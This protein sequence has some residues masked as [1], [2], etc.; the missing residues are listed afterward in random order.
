MDPTNSLGSITHGSLN[1][2][3]GNLIIE[4]LAR[5][6]VNLIVSSPGSRST[7]L[8]L[9]ASRNDRI[10]LVSFLDE[11][12]G[13]FYA[14]GHA[15]ASGKPAV[16]I[17]T[18]GTAAANYFPAVIEAK[19]SAVPLIVISCDRPFELRD[20]SAGQ[21]IDQVKLYG[22]YVNSFKELG[23]PENNTNYFNYLRQTI[24]HAYSISTGLLH[25]PVHL[26]ASFR[27]PLFSLSK[28]SGSNYEFHKELNKYSTVICKF[29]DV[30]K[31]NLSIDRLLLEKVQSHR[32]GII[33]VGNA[34]WI[35]S[36]R[37]DVDALARL[38]KK[39]G[40]P[41]LT[42]VL[43]PLR[44]FNQRFTHL[45]TNYNYILKDPQRIVD[46]EPT[47][48][49]QIGDLPTSK[50]L[51]SWLKG[52]KPSQFI[53]GDG[54]SNKDP[55]DNYTIPLYGTISSLDDALETKNT[56]EDWL[57]Q[58]LLFDQK[59][60]D[61]I[62]SYIQKV[63]KKFEGQISYML[64]RSVAKGTQIILANSMSVRYAEE[65]WSKND[66]L[67]QIHCNRGA[68]GI[69]GTVS[70]ALG[71]AK[72][73]VPSILLTGDL[74]FLHDS[75]GL[76]N[77]H[78]LDADI[79]II[80]VNNNGGGIFEHLAISNDPYFNDYWATPQN[81]SLSHFCKSL[82]IK[83]ECAENLEVISKIVNQIK[84]GG[85]QIVEF[86]CDRKKDA[87]ILQEVHNLFKI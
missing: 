57:A 43:N 12:S 15:K 6:G 14:L 51:R 85:V 24:V 5:L 36:E 50:T 49:L 58:W 4:V 17:C 42:D 3:C 55:L 26:N 67:C 20:C 73:G 29:S 62:V 16:I 23:L 53:L 68:N 87:E 27:E 31:P 46:L 28:E 48:V 74:A 30:P 1:Q 81:F 72:N 84:G 64:S 33:V 41:I 34:Q 86:K 39:L 79:L 7:P 61:Y 38:S 63:D 59:A 70:T 75:N 69:D 44:N 60:A 54:F 83:Y 10:S 80:V 78:K 76:L 65:F 45:I 82:S 21:T 9:A 22:T 52:V 56:D 66:S 8:I 77:H 47:A 19:M 32:R 11:R 40:W 35:S 13:S 37:G 2:F 25:G 71:I 18:S